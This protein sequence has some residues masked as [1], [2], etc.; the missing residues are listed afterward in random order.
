MKSW[1]K[2]IASLSLTLLAGSMFTVPAE[3][4]SLWLTS[5]ISL[6]NVTVSEITD[7]SAEVYFDY[8][9]DL[10]R[11]HNNPA[12]GG[13]YQKE[14]IKKVCFVATV[15]NVLSITPEQYMYDFRQPYQ[16]TD[17][18]DLCTGVDDEVLSAEQADEIYGLHHAEPLFVN[19]SWTGIHDK[20][21]ATFD[22]YHFQ[23]YKLVKPEQLQ[24]QGKLSISLPYLQPNMQY[25]NRNMTQYYTR[26]TS[27][28]LW[29][30]LMYKLE[31]KAQPGP[32][33][34]EDGRAEN[35]N[36]GS[37]ITVDMNE[38]S[39]GVHIEYT[40][41]SV[42]PLYQST[43]LIPDFKTRSLVFV[44]VSALTPHV[45]DIRWLADRGISTG[46]KEADGSSTFRGMSPVVRQ[47]MAAFLRREAK[48]RNIADARTWQPSAADWKRFRDVDRNTPHAEDIL[49][50][51]HAGI[52]EGWKEADGTAA[53]RGMSPV[54]R[55][56]MAAF[57]KRLAARAGRD[58]GVK[59]KTDFTDVTAATPHMAD[60]QWLGASGISQGYRNNDGSWRFEGMT[61]VYRQDM[62]A[63]IHR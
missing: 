54:V 37:P 36:W 49:W 14:D 52:S 60:V 46:W 34:G 17:A 9:F 7:T 6:S 16:G 1:K 32:Y 35:K 24:K 59:P 61:R 31:E 55:Q 23:R 8:D 15:V 19:N 47:D 62:A 29:W 20:K 11:L 57:L 56:D 4:V 43:V 39:L 27:D 44:D 38:L 22:A 50:L 13:D 48:N 28:G 58:G 42:S 53:F 26:H 40:D 21:V 63:F 5:P 18:P 2:A 25:G 45:D 10:E 33:D 51:A 12:S 3:A 41:G 30:D